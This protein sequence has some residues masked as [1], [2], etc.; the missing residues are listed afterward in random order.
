METLKGIRETAPLT[1]VI[2]LSGQGEEADLIDAVNRHVYAY[3]KKGVDL[4]V[5]LDTIERAIKERDQV[6]LTLE[7]L[8]EEAP[9]KELLLVG[10]HQ[11]NAHQIYDE[12]RKGSEIGNHFQI[13]LRKNLLDF[14]MP[15]KSIDEILGIE[16]VV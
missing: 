4:D 9:E 3:I 16:G 15:D 7:R 6:L 14:Q 2:I 12:V 13:E 5:Y 1:Q 8:A 10:R 11:Y